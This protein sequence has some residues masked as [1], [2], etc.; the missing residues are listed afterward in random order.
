MADLCYSQHGGSGFTFTREDV[1]EMDR[2]EV[3]F[4]L[5]ALEERRKK[6]AWAIRNAGRAPA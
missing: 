4:Y 5:D 2:E 3:D 6:E 1:L